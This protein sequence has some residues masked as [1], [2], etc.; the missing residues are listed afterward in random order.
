M[1]EERRNTQL[2][3]TFRPEFLNRMDAILTFAPLEQTQLE[4]IAQRM[5]IECQKRLENVQIKLEFDASVAKQLASATYDPTLGARPLRR[6]VTQRIENLLANEI[7][8]GHIK[9]GDHVRVL[10]RDGEYRCVY[11]RE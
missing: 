1:D 4:Q 9:A 3:Q 7:L 8:K 6:E 2:K 11:E 5:L 10:W